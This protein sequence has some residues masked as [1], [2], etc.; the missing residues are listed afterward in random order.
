MS[1]EQISNRQLF[2]FLVMR[3]S[4]IIISTLPALSLADALQDAW[5]SAILSFFDA[6]FLVLFMAGLAPFYPWVTPV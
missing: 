3:R 1:K 6:V 5:I 4:T 2:F